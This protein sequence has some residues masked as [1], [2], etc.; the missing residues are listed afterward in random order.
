MNNPLIGMLGGRNNPMATMG[1]AMQM[2][3]QIRQSGNPQAAI[4]MMAQQNPN[5]KKAMEMCQGKNP[6]QV[7]KQMCQQNGIDP[8]QFTG[9]MGR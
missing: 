8:G 3:N 9:M 6:E 1:Q 4:T 2:V 7:F 5:V